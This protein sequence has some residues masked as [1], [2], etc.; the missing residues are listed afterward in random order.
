MSA[1]RVIRGA[2]WAERHMGPVLGSEPQRNRR[3]LGCRRCTGFLS[4]SHQI[5]TRQRPARASELDDEPGDVG[6]LVWAGGVRE[7]GRPGRSRRFLSLPCRSTDDCEHRLRAVQR[8]LCPT[9][10][11]RHNPTETDITI[12]RYVVFDSRPLISPPGLYNWGTFVYILQ[13]ARTHRFRATITLTSL[14]GGR[15]S[16]KRPPCVRSPPSSVVNA[17]LA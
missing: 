12:T 13:E 9:L 11:R 15:E 6:R 14:Y 10:S 17:R 16:F 5:H 3:A 2:V 1:P 4:A 7:I 8:C